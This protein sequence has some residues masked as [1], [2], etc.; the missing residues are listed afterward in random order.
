MLICCDGLKKYEKKYVF[1]RWYLFWYLN[2][3]DYFFVCFICKLYDLCIILKLKKEIHSTKAALSLHT[4][5]RNQKHNQLIFI[6]VNFQPDEKIHMP[7]LKEKMELSTE[8]SKSENCLSAKRKSI[9]QPDSAREELTPPPVPPLPVNYQR[10][11]GRGYWFCSTYYG[12][13]RR[14]KTNIV[15]FDC[16]FHFLQQTKAIYRTIIVSKRSCVPTTRPHVKRNWNG[17][18]QC[19]YTDIFLRS[20]LND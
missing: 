19:V 2:Q 16:Q 3:G 12:F 15:D 11:D 14:K 8:L 20:T 4:N 5:V 17:N 6:F 7:I 9:D 10:S 18:C 1:C 13:E